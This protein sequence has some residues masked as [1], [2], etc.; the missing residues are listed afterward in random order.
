MHVQWTRT[1]ANA[2]AKAFVAWHR[3]ETGETCSVGVDGRFGTGSRGFATQTLRLEDETM[4]G[5]GWTCKEG[6]VRLELRNLACYHSVLGIMMGRG[7][8][9][10]W[11]HFVKRVVSF[12]LEQKEIKPCWVDWM[13]VCETKCHHKVFPSAKILERNSSQW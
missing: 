6:N 3:N 1:S 12:I 10:V 2:C 4:C 9:T 13:N 8:G 11:L 5:R 7:R